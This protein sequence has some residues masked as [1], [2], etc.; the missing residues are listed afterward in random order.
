MYQN[1]QG[2]FKVTDNLPTP[3]RDNTLE[4]HNPRGLVRKE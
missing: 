3:D 2:R 1:A 4:K